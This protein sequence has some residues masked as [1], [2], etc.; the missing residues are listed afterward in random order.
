MVLTA[1]YLDTSV[2]IK[3]YKEERFSESV[4]DL[5][6]QALQGTED[7]FTSRFTTLE[8]IRAFQKA[9]IPDENIEVN[10]ENFRDQPIVFLDL[11]ES[12]LKLAERVIRLLRMYASDAIHVSSCILSKCRKM[13]TADRRHMLRKPVV[14]YL[15]KHGVEVVPL[16]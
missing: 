9:G 10:L 13:Y 12:T 11:S 15:R 1:N 4:E 5:L 16:I 3:L 2:A 6:Y 7:V 8:L 14:D